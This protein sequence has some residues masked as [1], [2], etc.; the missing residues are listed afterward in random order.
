[1]M[2][3]WPESAREGDGGRW[4]ADWPETQRRWDERLRG[5]NISH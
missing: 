3:I 2:S 1:M 5:A 4:S